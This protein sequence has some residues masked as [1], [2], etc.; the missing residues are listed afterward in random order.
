MSAPRLADTTDVTDAAGQLLAPRLP[1]E[2]PGG[3]PRPD[4]MREVRHGIP[5]VRRGGGAWRV[6]PPDLPPGAAAGAALARL[7]PGGHA[8]APPGSAPRPGPPPHGAPPPACRRPPRGPTGD[9][10]R[11]RGAPGDEGA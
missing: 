4:P 2:K 3:R 9:H 6:M 7:A 5:S 10:H 11:P 8:A 1:P